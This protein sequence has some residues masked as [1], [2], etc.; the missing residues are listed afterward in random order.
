MNSSVKDILSIVK[1]QLTEC[2]ESFFYQVLYGFSLSFQN[3]PMIVFPALIIDEITVNHNISQAVVY[4][5]LF[6]LA[7]FFLRYLSSFIEGVQS[8]YNLKLPHTF[9]LKLARKMFMVD[10][11]ETEKSEFIDQYN[12]AGN[13]IF[14]ACGNIYSLFT[15]GLSAFV[16]IILLSYLIS[17]LNFYLVF[18]VLVFSIINCVLNTKSNKTF[19]EYQQS[20]SSAQRHEDYAWNL[21]SSLDFAKDLRT[22][23][24]SKYIENKYL[25]CADETIKIESEKTRKLFYINT[26][27]VVLSVLQTIILYAV[28]IAE[29]RN[30]AITIGS[31]TL[32]IGS[33]NEFAGTIASFLRMYES[34]KSVSYHYKAYKDFM[35]LPE[36]E[37]DCKEDIPSQPLCIEFRDVTFR[38]PGSDKDALY[39]FNLVI[40]P[41]EHIAIVG[42][43][44]AGKTTLIKLLTRLYQPTDG[45]ILINSKNINEYDYEQYMRLF[46]PVFQDYKLLAYTIKE[47]IAFDHYDEKRFKK[48]VNESGLRDV[49]DK[50]P[51]RENT[52]LRKDFEESGVELS[53]GEKQKVAIA[54]S[55]YKDACIALLDEPTAALDPISEYEMYK[56]FQGFSN[57]KTTLFISHRMGSTRFCDRIIVLDNG[58]L[59]EVGSHNELM[60][61]NGLYCSMYQKQA[62]YYVN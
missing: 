52:F 53:G 1:I 6:A 10:Y 19:A 42:D 47:N 46:S 55:F 23:A 21:F 58:K 54:R 26:I 3:I 28:M 51:N 40:H 33:A 31:F 2:K 12:N 30:G 41:Y 44:G 49:I 16:K 34:M 43:N 22:Y 18:L 8:V 4:I 45:E 50:L 59:V 39:K 36:L 62:S 24:G 60:K 35:D 29:Y 14:N 17:T 32:Y 25:K 5:C 37:G 7:V 38:Y 27:Q 9:I 20:L 56:Q 15:L 11:S 61:K 13:E 57:G 48:A